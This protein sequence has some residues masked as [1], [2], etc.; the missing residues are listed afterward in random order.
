MPKAILLLRHGEEP[1]VQP[2]LDLSGAGCKRA[3]RLAKFIPTEFGKPGAIF[4]A[5]PSPSS[6]RCFLTMRP[7]AASLGVAI[8]GSFK[9]DD[10]APL[11]FKL[12]GDPTLRTDLI[13]VC[14]THHE[15]PS[16]A[17]YLNVNRVDF[18]KRW[19]DEVFDRLYVLSYKRGT[20]PR[21]KAVI[22]PF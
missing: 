4:A 9:S 5:A 7:L 6:V 11:A 3:E 21:V 17:A 13:V 20:R 14:W 2:H 16:L 22:Q 15:L 1:G 8:D 10:Y 18:P 12:L 19:A